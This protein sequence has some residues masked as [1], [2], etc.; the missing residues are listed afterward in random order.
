MQ[1]VVYIPDFS[2][3]LRH[4]FIL[5]FFF[6]NITEKSAGILPPALLVTVFFVFPL[7]SLYCTGTTSPVESMQF[8][9][10]FS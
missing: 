5:F 2:L 8:F 10:P 9:Q 1:F 3:L 6:G 4:I 7:C